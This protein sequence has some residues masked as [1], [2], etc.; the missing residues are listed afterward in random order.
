MVRI[1]LNAHSNATRMQQTQSRAYYRPSWS[2][3][4][5]PEFLE[6]VFSR[7]Y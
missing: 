4:M 1:N 6:Y 3:N 2:L 7:K 5:T